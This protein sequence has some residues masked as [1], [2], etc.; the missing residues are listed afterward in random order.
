MNIKNYTKIYQ[1]V[2]I[3]MLFL[4]MAW[5]GMMTVRTQKFRTYDK[6]L[7]QRRG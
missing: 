4:F 2:Q 5:Q 1:S 3:A 7:R 6:Q